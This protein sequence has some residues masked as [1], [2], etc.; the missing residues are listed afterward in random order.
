MANNSPKLFAGGREGRLKCQKAANQGR[1]LVRS[2]VLIDFSFT[3]YLSY[4]R[5][6][7]VVS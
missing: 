4:K 7:V 2:K 1:S 3:D 6:I 5:L